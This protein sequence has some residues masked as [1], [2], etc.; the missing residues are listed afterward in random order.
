MAVEIA[1]LVPKA[2]SI[3]FALF[4]LGLLGYFAGLHKQFIL[5]KYKK[6]I[7]D[8]KVFMATLDQK[9]SPS[10][11]MDND[12]REERLRQMIKSG[13]PIAVLEKAQ[14][15]V[16]KDKL[17]LNKEVKK[18]GIQL[19]K[20]RTTGTATG[21]KGS[22]INTGATSG[23]GSNGGNKE[24]EQSGILP[25]SSTPTL[26]RDKPKLDIIKPKSKW[27]WNSIKS[28]RTRD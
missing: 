27:D 16:K 26:E 5:L 6:R 14:Q 20:T 10:L 25:V 15:L 2:L 19:S 7:G 13:Y 3:G 24:L 12:L 23:I 17:K 8:A 21:T 11:T 28:N 1:T 4:I 22:T 9:F 18:N